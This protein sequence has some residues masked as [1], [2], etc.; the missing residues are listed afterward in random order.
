MLFSGE[1]GRRGCFVVYPGGPKPASFSP[2]MRFSVITYE[3]VLC[4]NLD[5]VWKFLDPPRLE[6]TMLRPMN[7]TRYTAGRDSPSASGV[8]RRDEG[9]ARGYPGPSRPEYSGF[10]L[11]DVAG[12]ML[13]RF[14]IYFY[15]PFLLKKK[16]VACSPFCA[17]NRVLVG[18]NVFEFS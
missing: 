11:F 14:L 1:G 18:V 13:H 2:T 7:P 16:S 4:Q 5:D 10:F 6:T 8:E 17:T 3:P 9:I 15:I 12:R